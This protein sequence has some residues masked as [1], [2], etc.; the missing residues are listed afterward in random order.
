MIKKVL[1]WLGIACRSFCIACKP[2]SAAQVV[3]SLGATIGDIAQG[4]GTFFTSLGA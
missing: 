1:T 4:F 2:N 3:S